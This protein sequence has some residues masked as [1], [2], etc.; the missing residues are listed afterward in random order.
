MDL[1]PTTE[2]NFLDS[3]HPINGGPSGSITPAVIEAE[4]SSSMSTPPPPK[5]IS[6]S[7]SPLYE[8]EEF[9]EDLVTAP[10]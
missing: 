7:T 9:E 2:L 8:V 3:L 5:Q 4:P 1:E 6:D 10:R